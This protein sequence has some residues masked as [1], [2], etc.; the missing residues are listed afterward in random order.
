[1]AAGQNSQRESAKKKL[2]PLRGHT[3]CHTNSRKGT[4]HTS[5]NV[6]TTTTKTP[7]HN[8]KY[9]H[10]DNLKPWRRCCKTGFC[11]RNPDTAAHHVAM[12]F[13]VSTVR[14]ERRL[15]SVPPADLEAFGDTCEIIA[16]V[17]RTRQLRTPGRPV[18]EG[19]TE[20][21]WDNHWP[22]LMDSKRF[23]IKLRITLTISQS[24]HAGNFAFR[25]STESEILLSNV[26]RMKGRSLATALAD[27]RDDQ[28]HRVYHWI[29]RLSW[30]GNQLFVIEFK[31]SPA[32]L[33][34]PASI[35]GV[36]GAAQ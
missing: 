21:T 15:T 25:T 31:Q 29:Q 20:H 11:T 24:V 16:K 13:D 1:M 27:I 36:Q 9:Q 33:S 2:R 22:W 8:K 32:L 7:G 5:C 12:F 26:V 6:S 18:L 35:A 4:G 30:L 17:W 19:L 14:H 28:E 23:I 3:A 10:S 34:E